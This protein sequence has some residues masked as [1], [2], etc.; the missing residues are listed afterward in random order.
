VWVCVCVCGAYV[1]TDVAVSFDA[2]RVK[3][4]FTRKQREAGDVTWKDVS[5]FQAATDRWLWQVRLFL[6]PWLW[7]QNL[8]C[9]NEACVK[10]TIKTWGSTRTVLRKPSDVSC[11]QDAPLSPFPTYVKGGCLHATPRSHFIFTRKQSSA[12]ILNR[13]SNQPLKVR[14]TPW[15]RC[16]GAILHPL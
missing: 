6:L 3:T 1:I 5:T 4:F 9:E 13:K 15:K 12:V 10:A 14:H 11:K 7:H 8:V 16:R 2:L